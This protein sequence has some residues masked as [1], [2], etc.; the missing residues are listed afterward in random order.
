M[1]H[2]LC[3][4]LLASTFGFGVSN[5][6]IPVVGGLTN[7]LLA[8]PAYPSNSC[9]ADASN[10]GRCYFVC[11]GI[12]HPDY[13]I[14]VRVVGPEGELI[15]GRA[16]CGQSEAFAIC[17]GQG[18]GGCQS[19][20]VPTTPDSYGGCTLNVDPHQQVRSQFHGVKAVC[21]YGPTLGWG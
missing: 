5:A 3:A 21:S 7:N 10:G 16:D 18:D 1:R 12:L 14:T 6:G 2:I 15:G 8:D 4:A 20:A 17:L 13:A 11:N 9:T 19:S